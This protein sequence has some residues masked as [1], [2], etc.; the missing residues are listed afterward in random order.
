M[1]PAESALQYRLQQILS[2]GPVV[3][4]EQHGRGEHPGRRPLDELLEGG[5]VRCSMHM[6]FTSR[7][8]KRLT[9]LSGHPLAD[10]YPVFGDGATLFSVDED[11][12]PS[13]NGHRPR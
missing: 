7:H 8:D 12:R 9:E 4:G 1:P 6:A 3:T 11:G 2:I 10:G 5:P 13:W